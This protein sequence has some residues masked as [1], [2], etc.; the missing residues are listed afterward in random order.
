MA[1]TR[2][3]HLSLDELARL[4]WA[5]HQDPALSGAWQH[6]HTI[7]NANAGTK[8]QERKRIE[9]TYRGETNTLEDYAGR[10]PIELLQ[11]AQDAAAEAGRKDA[12]VWMHVSNSA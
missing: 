7:A 3:T 1:A 9:S 11:N 2:N 4:T 8:K 12:T 10:Y 5:G 6:L